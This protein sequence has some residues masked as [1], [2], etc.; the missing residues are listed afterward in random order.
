MI[1][2]HVFVRAS[3]GYNGTMCAANETGRNNSKKNETRS[4]WKSTDELKNRISEWHQD[5]ICIVC[6]A[7]GNEH[8]FTCSFRTHRLNPI[9]F[10]WDFYLNFY[11][12]CFFPCHSVIRSRITSTTFSI[13]TD[14]V[15][16]KLRKLTWISVSSVF[17]PPYV[18]CTGYSFSLNIIGDARDF[19]S[20]I[21]AFNRP[22]VTHYSTL[23]G[24]PMPNIYHID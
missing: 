22:S 8:T 18:T 23:F 5:R 13:H 7:A 21:E 4:T 3:T 20:R 9:I 6:R 10:R 11:S 17:R 1:L 19:L 2:W 12:L 24:I 16:E 14:A 15:V